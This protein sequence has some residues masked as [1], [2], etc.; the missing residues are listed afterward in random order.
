[1]TWSSF[2]NTG[3]PA[4]G[5]YATPEWVSDTLV[6]R[7]TG[8]QKRIVDLGVGKGAL[9]LAILNKCPKAK[10]IG[11]DKY[12]IP[13][14]ETEA[15][16]ARGIQLVS[17]DVASSKF[18]SWFVKTH[19]HVDTVISNPPF[20]YVKN[21]TWVRKALSENE[22]G[23]REQA[24]KQRSD[25]LFLT[26]ACRLLQPKGE[27]AFILPKS[28]FGTTRSSKYLNLMTEKLGLKEVVFL[29]T[30]TFQKAEVETAIF[31]FRPQAK[32]A[33]NGRITLLRADSNR[34]IQDLGNC[35]ANDL[36]QGIL[37]ESSQRTSNS[38]NNLLKLGAT[39]ARG[40][41]SSSVLSNFGLPHFHTTSFQK[42]PDF[43]V[44][45]KQAKGSTL[46]ED[47]PALEGDILIARVGSR[48]IGNVALVES[49]Q[50]LI[51][52]CIY[53]LNLPVRARRNVWEFMSSEAG[54]NWQHSLAR[55]ACAKFITQQDLLETSMPLRY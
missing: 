39:L 22:L 49:G 52:D 42:Y 19:G 18:A 53:K 47:Y 34:G 55:G 10:I 2:Q 11:I 44:A 12:S 20:T 46:A 43:K 5:Q 36:L 4:A 14:S 24:L 38:Q 6:E 21:S 13:M 41:H 48:C 28:V 9:A 3:D 32:P 16:V 7:L 35:L 15:M 29:P 51:S 1:M 8:K 25:L 17:R 31:I 33:L 27:I 45:F 30:D 50:Q 23:H 26:Q 40:R 54:R 37:I